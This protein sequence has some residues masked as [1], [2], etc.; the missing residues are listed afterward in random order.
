M[1]FTFLLDVAPE[2]AGTGG[3]SIAISL[4]AIVFVLAFTAVSL[5]TVLFVI[6]RKRRTPKSDGV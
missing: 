6:W 1:N 5:G 3:L 2:P 4:L